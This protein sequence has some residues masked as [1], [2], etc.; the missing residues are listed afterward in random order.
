[1]KRAVTRTEGKADQETRPLGGGSPFSVCL[2]WREVRM[3]RP[4]AARGH[5][6]HIRSLVV[7]APQLRISLGT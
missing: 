4:G 2:C 3:A 1:M 6:G 7:A 5:S